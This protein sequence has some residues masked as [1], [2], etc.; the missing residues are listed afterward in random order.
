[1]DSPDIDNLILVIVILIVKKRKLLVKMGKNFFRVRCCDFRS[2]LR[3]ALGRR[4]YR[5]MFHSSMK[6][7]KCD[8]EQEEKSN[9][10]LLHSS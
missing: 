7:E 3:K 2:I 1:M 9:K 10:E 6:G 4:S 5:E 8:E